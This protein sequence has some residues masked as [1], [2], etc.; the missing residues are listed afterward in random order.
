MLEDSLFCLSLD[1]HINLSS[2]KKK[3]ILQEEKVNL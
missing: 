2:I 3:K 1:W